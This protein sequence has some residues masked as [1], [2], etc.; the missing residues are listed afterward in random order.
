MFRVHIG[1][2]VQHRQDNFLA[3]PCDIAQTLQ[4]PCPP[5]QVVAQLQEH[6]QLNQ[7][8]LDEPDPKTKKWIRCLTTE[9]KRYNRL[10]V[11][12]H[13]KE[14]LPAGTTGRCT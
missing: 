2:V 5:Q 3:L 9:A 12:R 6:L 8:S 13:L 1:L 10:D 7:C 14:I 11:V 4:S